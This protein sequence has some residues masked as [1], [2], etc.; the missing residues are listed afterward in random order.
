MNII[1]ERDITAVCSMGSLKKNVCA[2][3]MSIAFVCASLTYSLIEDFSVFKD[4]LHTPGETV[5]F[6][7]YSSS[8]QI[9]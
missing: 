4:I 2:Q 7:N 3:I 1:L 5:C 8:T 6:P 9:W